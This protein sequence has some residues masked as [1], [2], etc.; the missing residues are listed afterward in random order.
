MK[1][2]IMPTQARGWR[3]LFLRWA[4]IIFLVLAGG[5]YYLTDMPGSSYQG[6]LAPFSDTEKLLSTSLR[7]HVEKLANDIGKR[8]LFTQPQ[9]LHQAEVYIEQTFKQL[10]YLV[11]VHSFQVGQTLANNL[12]VSLPGTSPDILPIM[13]LFL[14][15][16][17][18]MIMQRGLQLYWN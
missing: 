15:V 2:W 9:A 18:Q 10:G 14:Q 16:R 13:I 7:Q 11:H 5:K 3:N 4:I 12:W 8:S 17:V 6:A 1:A